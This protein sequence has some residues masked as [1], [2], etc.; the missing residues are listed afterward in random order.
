MS[1]M[2]MME[3]TPNLKLLQVA[4]NIPRRP[5][6]L[7]HRDDAKSLLDVRISVSAPNI[8]I[9]RISNISIIILLSRD[10]TALQSWTVKATYSDP[11]PENNWIVKKKRIYNYRHCRTRR[12]VENA[13]GILTQ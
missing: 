8:L 5:E 10:V 6:F 12:V 9:R 3:S 1:S 4:S 13:F 2:P 11:I 7:K